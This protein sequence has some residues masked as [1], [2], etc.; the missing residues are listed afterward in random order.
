MIS[1]SSNF[2]ITHKYNEQT[3]LKDKSTEDRHD[4][5]IDT[6]SIFN[7]K[8]STAKHLFTTNNETAFYQNNN[9]ISNFQVPTKLDMYT[10]AV[11]NVRVVGNK[12]I[13]LANLGDKQIACAESASPVKPP[14]GADNARALVN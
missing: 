2:G 14:S 7:E 6:L 4:H 11:S 12:L 1:T 13:V 5:L 9:A 10:A 8:L 3:Y